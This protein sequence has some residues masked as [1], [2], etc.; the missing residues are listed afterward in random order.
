MPPVIAP[1]VPQMKHVIAIDGAS[2]SGRTS[3]VDYFASR[4][5]TDLCPFHIDDFAG[6]LSPAAWDRLSGSDAGWDE[7]SMLFNQHLLE[8]CP[9]NGVVLADC[10]YKL[11][12]ARDHLFSLFGRDQVTYVQLYCELE[13]LER[14]EVLRGNRK[15]G[16]AR[17][18]FKAVYS[19]SGYDIRIDSTHSTIEACSR[20]LN[21]ALSN[22]MMQRI[23]LH[24]TAD[25]PNGETGHEH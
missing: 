20:D 5:A 19:Y 13:E 14:R 17:S 23:G 25:R 2:S 22:S 10:F 15:I 12:T 8:A 1:T 6:T 16:L 21:A 9:T 18:Q 24:P 4:V 11:G 3:L 7:I